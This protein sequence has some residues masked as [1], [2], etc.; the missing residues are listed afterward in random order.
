MSQWPSIKAKRLLA[1]LKKNG[2]SVKRQTGSHKTLE[3]SGFPDFIFAFHDNIEIGPKIL[4]RIAK[5][6]GLLPGD[7]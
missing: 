4:A 7:L 2:W 1:I 3:K 5:H 6:T